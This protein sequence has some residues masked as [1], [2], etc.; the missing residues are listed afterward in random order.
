MK[1]ALL[2]LFTLVLSTQ[3]LAIPPLPPMPIEE[4]DL[5]C[6]DTNTL[7][8]LEIES[9]NQNPESIISFDQ[10]LREVCFKKNKDQND[11]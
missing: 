6:K 7:T 11:Q 3:L 10:E 2:F 8:Q 4:N 5:V 1:S 9:L